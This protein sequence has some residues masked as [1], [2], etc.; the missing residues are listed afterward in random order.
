MRA[1][2]PFRL[3]EGLVDDPVHDAGNRF[4][5][6]RHLDGGGAGWILARLTGTP[7]TEDGLPAG[8]AIT[9]ALTPTGN[10]AEQVPSGCGT[11][12]AGVSGF[13]FVQAIPAGTV[14]TSPVPFP[15]T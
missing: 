7:N 6:E 4:G 8:V 5:V 9:D 12:P 3:R 1:E 10:R 11:V 15:R 14:V 2:V 13:S